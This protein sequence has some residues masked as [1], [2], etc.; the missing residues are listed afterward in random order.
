LTALALA[1]LVA[2]AAR[3][4]A[5]PLVPGASGI[6]PDVFA[7][8][9]TA[10][11]TLVATTGTLPWVGSFGL[12]AGTYV[13]SVYRSAAGTLDFT[14]HFTVTTGDVERTSHFNFAGVNIYDAGYVA[15]SGGVHPD[16]MSR[17]TSGGIA[18]FGFLGSGDVN[19]GQSSTID[20]LRTNAIAYTAGTY[21]FQDGDTSTV[22]AFAPLPPP[23]TTPEPSTIVSVLSVVPMVGF[24]L[25]RRRRRSA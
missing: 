2:F 10:G 7:T 9:P 22:L 19:A 21:T 4:N 24:Y 15:G 3:A 17:S 12:D 6:A 1:G 14:Y 18:S 16:T 8:D 25:A 11:E 20:V 23:A 5:G 13:A